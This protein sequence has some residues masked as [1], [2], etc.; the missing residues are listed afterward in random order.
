MQFELFVALRY[1]KAKRKQTF[2]SIITVISIAGVMVGV[3]ALVTVLAVMNGFQEDIKNKI[4]GITSHVIVLSASGGIQDYEKITREVETVDGVVAGTPFVLG[5]AMLSTDRAATGVVVRGIDLDTERRVIS[6]ETNLKEGILDDLRPSGRLAGIDSTEGIIIGKE[7]A[8]LLG[9]SRGDEINMMSP[10]GV[11]TPVGMVP[12]MRK[13]RVSGIFESGMYEYD[14]SLV[15]LELGAAQDF[16]GMPGRVT[17]IEVRVKDIYQAGQVSHSI[18]Q[19]LGFPYWTKDW[20]Q[21]NKSLF[22]ALKLE[23]IMMFILLALIIMVAA[24]NIIGTLIL[25]VMEKTRDIAILKSMGATARQILNVFIINGVFVGVVGTVL[26][27]VGGYG[28]CLLLARYPFPLPSDVYQ[29]S[30]LPIKP[31]VFDFL[32]VA[33]CAIAISFMAT[34]YPSWHASQLQPAEAL[35]YE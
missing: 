30:H 9:V 10:I 8:H 13:F 5:Q 25:V 15:F 16:F 24:F 3:M 20:I 35:R 1:L 12:K 19:K 4:L 26:G 32:S 14:S 23:K 18:A 34:V 17:G 2:I 27:L 21:M 6:L 11:M 29:L 33:V 22:S 28:L 7:L 31:D